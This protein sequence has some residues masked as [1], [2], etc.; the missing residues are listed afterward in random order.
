M[1]DGA[2]HHPVVGEPEGGHLELG[3]ARAIASILQ[4]PSSSEYSLCTCRWTADPLTARSSQAALTAPARVLATCEDRVVDL[5][6]RH[7][8]ASDDAPD[9]ASRALT[10]NGE[11][12]ARVAGAALNELGVEIDRC[13]TSP[14]L[15]AVQTARLACEPLGVSQRSA[16]R[17]VAA[18]SIRPGSRPDGT[19]LLVGHEPDLS[20]AIQL[21]TGGRADMRKEAVSQ[22][23][24]NG[25]WRRCFSPRRCGGSPA[26]EPVLEQDPSQAL[27]VP[28]QRANRRARC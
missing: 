20:R 11:R 4:A 19:V 3:R 7:G 14:K 12:Q 21:T 9:D 23:S 15:R 6:P 5:A 25:F 18:T 22:R 28:L 13:L 26:S 1:L 16:R 27:Q 10:A 8:E 17:W 24:T 2:V